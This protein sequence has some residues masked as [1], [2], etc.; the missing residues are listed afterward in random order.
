MEEKAT[1][2]IASSTGKFSA[3]LVATQWRPD[4]A[5]DGKLEWHLSGPD[6][7]Y[8]SS[9]AT[10]Y[11]ARIEE[12]RQS[13]ERAWTAAQ[14]IAAAAG[15]MCITKEIKTPRFSFRVET[16]QAGGAI[17]PFHDSRWSHSLRI[18]GRDQLSELFAV[19]DEALEKWPNLSAT[20]QPPQSIEPP[21]AAQRSPGR[22]RR[23]LGL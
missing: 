23:A 12:F 22:I 10:L 20:I 6:M 7:R 17:T 8:N 5:P 1:T 21:K 16:S 2:R 9:L 15:G 18:S 3:T 13:A 11:V 4:M 19:L 14:E